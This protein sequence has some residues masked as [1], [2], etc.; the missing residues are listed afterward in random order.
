MYCIVEVGEALPLR[1][2]R[3]RAAKNLWHR[4]A[5]ASEQSAE[6]DTAFS[7]RIGKRLQQRNDCHVMYFLML[8]QVS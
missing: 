2:V 7:P 3:L 8:I 6:R 1:S 4:T 5:A